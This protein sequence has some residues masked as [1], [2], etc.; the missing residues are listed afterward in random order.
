[1]NMDELSSFYFCM[2]FLPFCFSLML[3][4]RLSRIYDRMQKLL[5]TYEEVVKRGISSETKP[6]PS[7]VTSLVNKEVTNVEIPLQPRLP[8]IPSMGVPA[9]VSEV[10]KTEKAKGKPTRLPPKR[11]PKTVPPVQP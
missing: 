9:E 3:L 1:M 10:L 7:V 8:E 2:N 5:Q 6:V 4:H 11:K